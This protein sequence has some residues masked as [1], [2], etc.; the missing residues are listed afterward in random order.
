MY[1]CPPTIRELLQMTGLATTSAVSHHIDRLRASG[2]LADMP[3]FGASR[4]ITP[5][6]VQ[7]AID[8]YQKGRKG[9]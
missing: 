2:Y 8:D 7:A 9:T 4:A 5:V 1:F 3:Y 6:W